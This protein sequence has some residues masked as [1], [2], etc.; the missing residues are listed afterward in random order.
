[1]GRSQFFSLQPS[2]LFFNC[3]VIRGEN[4]DNGDIN[5]LWICSHFSEVDIGKGEE[6]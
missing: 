3:I 2:S 5:L 4:N 6:G 1:M